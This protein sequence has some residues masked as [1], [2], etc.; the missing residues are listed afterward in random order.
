MYN[1]NNNSVTV[2]AQGFPADY[3]YNNSVMTT[4]AIQGFPVRSL[5]ITYGTVFILSGVAGLLGNFLSCLF[6]RNKPRD[7]SSLLYQLITLNDFLISCLI[8]PA[9][10]CFLRN[11]SPGV[12]QDD[13]FCKSWT[14]LWYVA[15][16]LSVF[17]VVVLTVSRTVSIVRP[18]RGVSVKW[19]VISIVIYLLYL[20]AQFVVFFMLDGIIVVFN[21]WRGTC[22]VLIKQDMHDS[23]VIKFL[24]VSMVLAI[25]CPVFIVIIN[26]IISTWVLCQKRRVLVT[27][28]SGIGRMKLRASVTILL[29]GVVY[30]VFNVPLA[31]YQILQTIDLKL[32][33]WDHDPVYFQYFC[34]F[35]VTGCVVLNSAL[36]PFLYYWRMD[37]FRDFLLDRDYTPPPL[38]QL[39]SGTTR[40]RHSFQEER[41]I[42]EV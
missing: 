16:R 34:V 39:G 30:L 14:L 33:S 22:A 29:F 1:Y 17:L 8:F 18:L 21:E 20:L 25:W 37:K 42:T 13:I 9:G 19:V 7:L 2:V 36:N 26:T 15:A 35:S 40:F 38:S 12:F 10:V 27:H 31:V 41:G 6:F 3:Y 24:E 4:V 11:R 5:D 23:G 32:L 28:I